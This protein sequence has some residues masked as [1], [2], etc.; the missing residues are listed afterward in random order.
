MVDD[1][2]PPMIL[3]RVDNRLRLPAWE[4]NETVLDELRAAC[5]HTNPAK[6]KLDRLA[7]GARGKRGIAF[8]IAAK[9]EPDR[10]ETWAMEGDEFTLPRGALGKLREVLRKHEIAW[11]VDDCRTK[12]SGPRYTRQLVHHPNPYAPDGGDLRWYQE[13]AIEAAIQ[14]QN[15]I[16]RAPT[17]SGKTTTAIGLLARLRLPTLIVVWTSGLMEQWRER[18]AKELRL[19]VGEIG[20]IG[21]GVRVIKPIT[22]AMQQSLMKGNAEKLRGVF[23]LVICDEVQRF[24][25]AT[26][27]G[28]ID[29]FDAHY[30]IGISA[31][32]TRSDGKEFLIYDEF[33]DVA[34][35]VSR[36]QLIDAGAVLDVECRVIPTDFKADWYVQERE[37]GG[38]PNHTQLIAE[39][40]ADDERTRLAVDVAV[41][42]VEA[43]HQVV[44]LT[45]R[46]EHAKRIAGDLIARGIEA[47]TMLGGEENKARFEEARGRLKAGHLRAVAATVQAM[48]TGIDIPSL[49]RGI[50][51][52]PIGANKQ[53][54]GQIRGRLCR[55]GKDDAVLYVLWD[56]HVQGAASL[57]RYGAWNRTTLV[58]ANGEWVDVRTWMKGAN[59]ATT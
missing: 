56:R 21:G 25:A 1:I 24:G 42:E 47:D 11:K 7:R 3:I 30:R 50:L 8:R 44:V 14:R 12:G 36:E 4:L 34:H 52:T 53:L 48:G 5:T 40:S 9:R 33:G 51:A 57:K 6:F 10:I 23:G 31:D 32:E 45:H 13:E 35:E 20:Q 18:I 39:M 29:A 22:L 43:G 37:A 26:F 49:S 41:R 55:T 46:V 19:P 38:S 16:V 2:E 27:L 58:Q 59:D 17:G 54:Y 15:C 28:V